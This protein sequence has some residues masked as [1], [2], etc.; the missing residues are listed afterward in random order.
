MKTPFIDLKREYLS[1]KKEVKQRII[2]VLE[3]GEYVY[4]KETKRFE[5]KFAKLVGSNYCLG[6][7]SGT[8][9]LEIAL[10]ALDIGKGDEVITTPLTFIATV[11]AIINV[12][13][14]PVF[15]DISENTL[16][17]D[18]F[19]MEAAVTKKTR[20]VIPV[21]LHGMCVEMDPLLKIAKKCGLFVIEDASHAIGSL[22]RGKPVGSLGDIGC[23]SLYPSKSFGAYGNAG[24]VVTKSRNYNNKMR[25]LADHGRL[26]DRNIHQSIGSTLTINNI[27]SA[28]LNVKLSRFKARARKK[29]N[30]AKR[31][32]EAF[33]GLG[34]IT[35]KI[36]P[37]CS[38]VFYVYSILVEKRDR[39]RNFMHK[40]GV[41]T[42]IYYPIPLHL[43]PSLAFLNYKK[44]AFPMVEKAA[45]TVVSLPF[46]PEMT[47]RE[48][49]YVIQ[50]VRKYFN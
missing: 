38:P 20:A 37:H 1:I 8:A 32:T 12:G 14:R 4:G 43:Q 23:Y 29:I 13:A 35:P 41:E 49:E 3:D 44:N 21:H 48:V 19:G 45:K 50:I 7:S 30:I 17:L 31:Y 16:N 36:F 28:I 11:E 22:Y 39:F 2:K 5:K 33:Q 25:M 10:R 34:L 24:A 15:V 26:K 9:S 47:N 46:Y 6:T 40:H 27:Q 18:V 42:R